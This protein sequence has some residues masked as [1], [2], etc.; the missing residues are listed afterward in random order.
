[1]DFGIK[2]ILTGNTINGNAVNESDEIGKGNSQILYIIL[3]FFVVVILVIGVVIVKIK[4]NKKSKKK[5]SKK[6]IGKRIRRR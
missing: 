2:A 3:S 1:M 5:K 4:K 6:K